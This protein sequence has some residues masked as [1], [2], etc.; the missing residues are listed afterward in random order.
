VVTYTGRTVIRGA[1]IWPMV[2][3]CALV[4]AQPATIPA[5]VRAIFVG[6]IKGISEAGSIRQALIED[7]RKHGKPSLAD[8][9]DSADATLTGNGELW[10][11]GYYSLNPRERSVGEDAHR[12]YGGYL[13]VELRDRKGEV[14]WSYLVTPR[15][16]Y[17]SV[18][19]DL[20][21]QVLKKLREATGP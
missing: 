12:V 5:K 1:L 10:V 13:S 21:G 14:L 8:G 4:F 11:K 16:G 7:L 9:P 20:A 17:D 15:R 6:D 18:G 3:W 19:H 2:S